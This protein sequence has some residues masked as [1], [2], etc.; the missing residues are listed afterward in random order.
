MTS[1]SDWVDGQMQSHGYASDYAFAQALGVAH[2]SPGRW[3][4]SPKPPTVETM[5]RL[6][7]FFKAPMQDV[8]VAAGY[9]KP[10]ESGV[11]RVAQAMQDV[12][13][14][15]L[16]REIAR[17]MADPVD[18]GVLAMRSSESADPNRRGLRPHEG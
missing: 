18:F 3:R 4:T 13:N 6:A 16:L 10:E 9:L 8:L 5:R 1:F 7:E 12:T 15:D 2:T 17:R 14:E 11:V